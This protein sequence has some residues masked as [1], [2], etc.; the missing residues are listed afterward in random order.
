MKILLTGNCQTTGIAYFLRRALPS[1]EIRDLPHLGTF[2]KHI[3]EEEIA[4][5]HQWADLVFFH[6]KHDGKQEYPTKQPK[7]PL[8]VWYQSAPF[9][10]QI[11]QEMWDEFRSLNNCSSRFKTNDIL[12]D[13]AVK[14]NDFDYEKRWND[15]WDKMKVKEIDE[16]VPEDIRASTMMD[17]GRERQLQLTCNHPT[18]WVFVGW[19]IKILNFLGVKSNN[20]PTFKEAEDHPN[21]AGLPCEES[22]TSGARK[23]LGLAWGGRPID[24]ESGRQIARERLNQ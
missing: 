3:S 8:S 16:G 5:A 6:H 7:I 4:E 14:E 20:Y 19:T 1:W 18:S 22:A 17:R 11:T 15:C 21:L 9:M 12:V 24:D 2:F 10:A 13:Y 23:H